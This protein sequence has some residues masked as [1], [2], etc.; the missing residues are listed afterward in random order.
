MRSSFA[1][2]PTLFDRVFDLLETAFPGLREAAVETRRLGGFWE[3]VSTPFLH[4][5]DGRL[6]AHVGLI[7]LPLVL[8]GRPVPVGSIHAVVTHSGH[9]RR[10]HCRALMLE[11]LQYAEGRYETL[12]L[13]T[14]EPPI[15][16]PYG[17]RVLAE[18]R[19]TAAVPP[20][21]VSGASGRGLRR[22]DL[23]DPA[24]LERLTGLLE[25]RE[26]VSRVVGCG[27]ART[28]FLFNEG[29]RP[30]LYTED[31]NAVLCMETRG[32]TL[33]LHDVV[34]PEMPS[35]DAIVA[36]L[37][38]PVETVEFSFT[39]D[40]L[41]PGAAFA[42]EVPDYGG[43]SYLMARGPFAAEG[44]PFAFPRSART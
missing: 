42:P 24:D 43:P 40:R 30:L 44:R 3:A 20:G 12:V 9:R 28:V 23:G 2:D 39:P 16:E 36:A 22:L 19:F 11:A 29:H 14:E 35:L 27:N 6:V 18:H 25:A 4:L 37:G 8:A 13:T 33:I 32:R 26:P 1:D 17:F 5:E 38:E 34:A 10:G 7:E 41:A 31:L 21:S 15:Y